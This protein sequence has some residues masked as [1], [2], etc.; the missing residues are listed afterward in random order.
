[1]CHRSGE[2]ND[3]VNLFH[4]HRRNC[5]CVVQRKMIL[6]YDYLSQQFRMGM[7]LLLGR[8]NSVCFFLE[9]V[10]QDFGIRSYSLCTY[11]PDYLGND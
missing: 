5:D 6:V 8:E 7:T 9:L 1:M 11:A 4:A 2:K 10:A 3:G